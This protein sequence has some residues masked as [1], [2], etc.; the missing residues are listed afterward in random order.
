[1]RISSYKSLI[2][3]LP[4]RNQGFDIKKE[5]WI[6]EHQ[7]DVV[8]QIFK[9]KDTIT[10]SRN[11]LFNSNG[12]PEQFII[13]TLM[14]G[15]PTKGRGR[16]IENLL[17]DENFNELCKI[18]EG[19]K[20][21]NISI[22]ILEKDINRVSGLGISTMTK[23]TNFLNTRINGNRSV[24]LDLQIINVLNLDRFEE[25]SSLKGIRYDNAIRM[26]DEYLTIINELS[27]ELKIKPDQIELFLF[28]FGNSLT[29]LE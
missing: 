29:D 9:G 21:S 24:I 14:W 5:I 6:T 15:F 16:N 11:H 12:N 1:M 2:K 17:K 7:K 26:Y 22:D 25:L 19:Y 3:E 10:I 13:K 20:E 8:D 27:K 4:Y 23:F 18:V 28:T